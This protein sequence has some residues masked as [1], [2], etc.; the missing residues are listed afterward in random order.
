LGPRRKMGH[1]SHGSL[2]HLG[3]QIVKAIL[4]RMKTDVVP[5]EV[6]LVLSG[7]Q[8]SLCKGRLL[9]PIAGFDD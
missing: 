7:Q 5:I 1:V 3:D 8:D 9:P 4:L 6:R 2:S